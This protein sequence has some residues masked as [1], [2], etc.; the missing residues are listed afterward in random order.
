MEYPSQA[1]RPQRPGG[2]TAVCVIAIVLGCLGLCSVLLGVF[3]LAAAPLMKRMVEEQQRTAMNNPA[4][5][6]NLEMQKKMQAIGDRHWG[7]SLA[8]L[9]ANTVLAGSLLA[10]GI[11]ALMMVPKARTFLLAVF[12]AAIAFVIVRAVV[13]AFAQMEMAAAISDSMRNIMA[14]AAPP[15]PAA[16]QGAAQ[17][18]EMATVFTKVGVFGGI[19]ITVLFA[20]A[21]VIFYA[22]GARYLCRPN[23]RRLFEPN[24][25]QF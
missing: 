14:T 12:V 10:G 2:L 5:N 9:L 4:H 17:A 11:A 13:E 1:F 18:A 20:L 19:A 7:S 16:R 8:F 3:S 24:R 23:I 15:G 25:G 6:A 21:K 22:I